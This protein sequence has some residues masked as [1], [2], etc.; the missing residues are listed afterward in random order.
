[1]IKKIIIT[2]TIMIL[3]LFISRKGSPKGKTPARAKGPTART[4]ICTRSRYTKGIDSICFSP[5][6][7]YMITGSLDGLVKLWH[8]GSGEEAATP[9]LAYGRRMGSDHT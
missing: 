2:I 4:V 8:A 1:M 9:G 6:G 7:R 5:D 3:T